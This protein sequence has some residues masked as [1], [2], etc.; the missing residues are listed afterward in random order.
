ME[1]SAKISTT[2]RGLDAMSKVH[3][4]TRGWFHIAKWNRVN[5]DTGCWFN[6]PVF[7]FRGFRSISNTTLQVGV[8]VVAA[9]KLHRL[10]RGLGRFESRLNLAGLCHSTI[11]AQCSTTEVYR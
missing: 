11:L 5:F 9:S 4:V 10:K 7:K 8:F 2:T 6:L 3:H 1:L